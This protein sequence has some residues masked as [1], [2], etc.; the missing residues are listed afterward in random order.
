LDAA[1]IHANAMGMKNRLLNNDRAGFLFYCVQQITCLSTK[2]LVFFKQK[3]IR[4]TADG[5]YGSQ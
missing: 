3:A 5:L 4:K 1:F 2:S